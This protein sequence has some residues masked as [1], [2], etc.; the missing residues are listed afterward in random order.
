MPPP[1][2]FHSCHCQWK[3]GV[4][5][6]LYHRVCDFRLMPRQTNI[7]FPAKEHYHFPGLILTSHPTEDMR[8]NWPE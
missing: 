3:N 6:G 7:I 1:P 2:V 8:L 4:V 5:F